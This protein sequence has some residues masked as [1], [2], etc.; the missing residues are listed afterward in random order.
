MLLPLSPG[1]ASSLSALPDIQ[2][3]VLL[4][5]LAGQETAPMIEKESV[6]IV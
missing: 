2:L 4:A 6:G 3:P 5:L 1:L